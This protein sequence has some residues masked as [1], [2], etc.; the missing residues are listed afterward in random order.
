MQMFA[1]T[2]PELLDQARA[3]E[4]WVA[5]HVAVDFYGR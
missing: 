1:H 3:D 4:R 2:L 5:Q